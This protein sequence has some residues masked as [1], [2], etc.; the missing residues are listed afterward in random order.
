MKFAVMLRRLFSAVVLVLLLTSR[1]QA[2]TIDLVLTVNLL[3]PTVGP[4]EI[5]FNY[6][7]FQSATNLWPFL[8]P[9]HSGTS[10]GVL[11]PGVWQ[12]NVSLDAVSL[13]N[14]YFTGY[15][16]YDS[17]FLPPDINI[18]VAEPPTG[19]VSDAL[20]YGYGPPWIS[21]ANMGGGYSGELYWIHGYS[22]G[23]IGTWAV[24]TAPTAVPEPTSLLLLG[25][26]LA[27][28][29]AKKYRRSNRHTQ[30]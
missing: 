5:S 6:S 30:S 9:F 1:A 26:G 22:R 12:F 24:T 4:P 10:A 28:V 21:L 23:P 3:E 27:A 20:A 14:V 16:F 17:P 8:A 25:S 15:G 11:L 13:D 19:R 29:V 2:A 18:Y 7:F